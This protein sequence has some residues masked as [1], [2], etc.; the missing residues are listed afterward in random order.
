MVLSR[1]IRT[2]WAQH[3]IRELLRSPQ[4]ASLVPQDIAAAILVLLYWWVLM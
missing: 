1:L 2:T 3:R 4:A